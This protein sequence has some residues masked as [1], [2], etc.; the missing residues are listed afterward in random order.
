MNIKI[1]VLAVADK[2]VASPLLWMLLNKRGNSPTVE[3]M[4]LLK[5]VLVVSHG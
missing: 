2:G 3:R 4:A 5:H 1:L